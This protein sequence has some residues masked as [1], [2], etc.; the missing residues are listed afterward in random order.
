MFCGAQCDQT[1]QLKVAQFSPKL[2]K[3]EQ[4]QFF[5]Y[6]EMFLK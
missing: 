5:T 6:T 4:K 3:K 1:L 2:P